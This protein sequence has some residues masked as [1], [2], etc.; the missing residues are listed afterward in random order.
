MVM[1]TIK[2]LSIRK[3]TTI[4]SIILIVIS[5]FSLMTK[6]LNLDGSVKTMTPHELIDIGADII[7]ANTYHLMIRPGKEILSS[8]GG[9]HQMMSWPK[10]ILTDSGGYQIWSLSK[11]RKIN[12]EFVEFDSPVNGD[13]IRLTPDR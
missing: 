13:L 10:P 12:D 7:L 3:S 9:L 2:F 5:G 8:H 1:N 6:G 4:M 11:K